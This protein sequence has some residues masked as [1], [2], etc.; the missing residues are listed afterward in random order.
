MS[1][2]TVVRRAGRRRRSPSAGGRR[3]YERSGDRRAPAP[4]RPHGPRGYGGPEGPGLLSC[5]TP[6]SQVPPILVWSPPVSC[7]VQTPCSAGLR[8]A[9]GTTWSLWL[10][11][12]SQ[13]VPRPAPSHPSYDRPPPIYLPGPTPTFPA[14]EPA[15]HHR[16]P[17]LCPPGGPRPDDPC[18]SPPSPEGLFSCPH[19][20]AKTAFPVHF[21]LAGTRA[22]TPP[23]LPPPQQAPWPGPLGA[24][25]FEGPCTFPPSEGG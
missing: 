5:Q 6:R 19:A 20:T 8:R 15:S 13:T 1:D 11:P 2:W 25:G 4:S 10:G 17:G 22:H 12:P 7:A 9:G 18:T 21:A 14:G 23:G 3:A 16:V 24:R